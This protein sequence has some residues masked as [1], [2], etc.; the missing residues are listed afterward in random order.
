MGILLKNC[1]AETIALNALTSL[2]SEEENL[3]QFLNQTGATI[4]DLHDGLKDPNFLASILQFFLEQDERLL[5][6]CESANIPPEQVKR[7][8]HILSKVRKL[9]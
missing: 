2:I 5:T 9:P 6:F 1:N 4:E 8:E 3:N 7:A